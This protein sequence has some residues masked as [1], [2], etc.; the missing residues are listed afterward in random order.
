MKVAQ[1]TEWGQSPKTKEVDGPPAPGPDEVQVKMLASGVHRLVQSR[2]AGKHYS[3]RGLP[4]IPGVDGVG[5]K[6]DGKLVYFFT[7]TPQGGSFQE[8]LNVPKH[9][10]IPVPHGGDLVQVAGLVNPVMASWMGIKYRTAN[11]PKDFSVLILGVTSTSGSVAISVARALG[12]GKVYGCAR[13]AAKMQPLGLDG[14]IELKSVAEETDFTSVADV[15]LVLDFLYGPATAQ[16]LKTA[17]PTTPM[18]YVQIGT[19][20][21]LTMELPGDLLRSKDITLRG[22]GPGSWRMQQYVEQ[23]PGMVALIASG[24]VKKQ[25][26]KE[27]KLDDVEKAWGQGGSDRMMVVP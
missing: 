1:V 26:F 9:A 19:V 11:L 27:I 3:A 18:Q 23:L 22:T 13:S 10:V 2:A 17:K 14:T 12:A 21:D 16:F 6:S 8:V 24:K 4:H 7:M 15:D 5:E 20:V 25:V